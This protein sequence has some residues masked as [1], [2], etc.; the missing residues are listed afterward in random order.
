MCL[1]LP[2]CKEAYVLLFKTCDTELYFTTHCFFNK[3]FNKHQ[4]LDSH[5]NARNKPLCNGRRCSL[6]WGLKETGLLTCWK[7]PRLP[8]MNPWAQMWERPGERALVKTNWTSGQRFLVSSFRSALSQVPLHNL[9]PS[10]MILGSKAKLLVTLSIFLLYHHFYC[11]SL[12][13]AQ[14]KNGKKNKK[15]TSI[16]KSANYNI[17]KGN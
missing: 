11:E 6:L 5:F 2:L 16:R 8:T 1:S 10:L 13:E 12:Y 14:K 17:H 7:G 4:G 9:W 3:V 15:T